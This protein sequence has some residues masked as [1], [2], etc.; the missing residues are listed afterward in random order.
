[1]SKTFRHWF[2]FPATCAMAGLVALILT[3]HPGLAQDPTADT[4]RHE[5]RMDVDFTVLPKVLPDGSEAP[6]SSAAP[7]EETL[8]PEPALTDSADDQTPPPAEEPAAAAKAPAETLPK[9]AQPQQQT[10]I[11]A[12]SPVKGTGVIRSISLDETGQGFSL[13]VVADRP[14]GQATFM[15]LDNPR[16]LV[17]DMLGKWTYKGGNVLRSEGVVKHVVMGEH[18]DH[19]RLV[20]HFRTPPRKAVTPELRSAGDQLHV[21][22]TLP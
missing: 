9:P 1:M 17:V 19:F 14:V 5:V 10:E 22:V 12:V 13:D 4:T 16:R 20:I 11:P 8:D 2:L 15:N 6:A 3:A 21:L 7:N 18:P